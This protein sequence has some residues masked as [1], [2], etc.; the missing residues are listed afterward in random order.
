[1]AKF[2]VVAAVIIALAILAWKCLSPFFVGKCDD[3]CGCTKPTIDEPLP[4]TIE[5][6]KKLRD[7]H[8]KRIIDINAAIAKKV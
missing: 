3:H 5:E 4:E 2:L 1:M 6:L 8:E 7:A